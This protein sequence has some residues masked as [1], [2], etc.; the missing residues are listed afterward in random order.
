MKLFNAEQLRSW[1]K[2]SIESQNI[3]SGALMQRASVILCKA[4]QSEISKTDEI[5]VLCGLGN[6]GGDGLFIAHFLHQLGYKIQVILLEGKG[7]PDRETA[8]LKLHQEVPRFS[9]DQT[10]WG[11]TDVLIDALFGIGISRPLDGKLLELVTQINQSGNKIISI[12]LPSGMPVDTNTEEVFPCI[13]AHLTLTIQKPKISFFSD[14]YARHLGHVKT[15]DIDLSPDFEKKQETEENQLV[16]R[17]ILSIYKTRNSYQH[18]G[19]YGRA[20]LMGGNAQTGGAIMLAGLACINTG[21]GLTTLAIPDVLKSSCFEFLPEAMQVSSGN[22]Y[23]ENLP[24][25][26]ESFT[27]IAVGPGL[28]T[29]DSSIEAIRELIKV[30]HERMVWDADA[31]NILATLSKNE[32]PK[33]GIFTPHP[34]EFDRLF[35]KHKTVMQ[36]WSTAKR[37]AKEMNWC[38]LLKGANSALFFPN[39]QSYYY[40]GEVSALAKGGSGDVLTGIICSL[41]SQQYSLE[42]ALK[43]GVYLHGETARMVSKNMASHSVKARDICEGLSKLISDIEN[44]K[45]KH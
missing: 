13:H 32:W 6:N 12:D 34:G 35:G 22:Q 24:E 9:P 5:A 27:S 17:D 2:Y 40:K 4:I 41:L 16:K 11:K 43:M 7:S 38:I 18:K 1:D 15:V 3:S 28:G 30:S 31:L 39:G 29:S 20:L 26:L 42:E 45:T 10:Q 36:R 23:L 19:T 44:E 33:S 8:L 14:D 37:V 25:T 21:A